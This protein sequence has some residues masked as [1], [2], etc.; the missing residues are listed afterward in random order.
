MGDDL[1][2]GSL[3]HVGASDVELS[4]SPHHHDK[5]GQGWGVDRSAGGGAE[6][7]GDLR[8]NAGVPDVSLKDGAVSGEAVDALLDARA[9]RVD[10]ADDGRA[11]IGREVHDLADFLGDH[12][13]QCATDYGEVLGVDE[14][15]AA[16]HLA[17]ACYD[18]IAEVL[19]VGHPELGGAVLH[20]GVELLEGSLVEEEVDTLAGG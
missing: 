3:H 17:V 13:G 2:G 5:V 9:A 18:G 8:N 16:G 7:G 10:E 20:K 15:Q 14:G 19:T 4:D 12:F 1:A 6:H 11:A